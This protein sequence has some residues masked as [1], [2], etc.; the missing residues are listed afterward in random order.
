MCAKHDIPE[1]HAKLHMKD[2]YEER[3]RHEY[4]TQ[5]AM[6]CCSKLAEKIAKFEDEPGLTRAIMKPWS[7]KN[8]DLA[9]KLRITCK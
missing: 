2:M 6:K 7:N 9:S 3:H 4:D 1:I 8:S 5:F